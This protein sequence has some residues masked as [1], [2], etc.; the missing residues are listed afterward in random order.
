MEY[1]IK[2]RHKK[3]EFANTGK[4]T[5]TRNN[6][7][8]NNNNKRSGSRRRSMNS[9][10]NSHSCSFLNLSFHKHSKRKKKKHS[11]QKG[12]HGKGTAIM[13]KRNILYS[14]ANRKKK[15]RKGNNIEIY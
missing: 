11:T 13:I 8:Q 9:N 14:M 3:I 5:Q 1:Y 4:E 10:F 15:N 12:S 2:C 7:H 6:L